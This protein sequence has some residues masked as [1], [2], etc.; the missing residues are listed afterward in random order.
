MVRVF[1][2]TPIL[3][4]AIG[5]ILFLGFGL[6]DA[7]WEGESSPTPTATAVPTATSWPMPTPF[8]IIRKPAES[9]DT[10]TRE[11]RWDYAGHEWTWALPVP[12]ALYDHYSSI[13]RAPTENY[14][15]YVTHPAD[16]SYV[17]ALVDKIEEAAE[18]EGFDEW[19]TVNFAVCFVQSL[20]YTSD[21]AT[22]PYDEYPRYPVETLVDGG[23]DCED[24]SILMA[25]VLDEMGYG[26]IL[27]SLPQHMAVGV[28]GGEGTYGTYW[29]HNGKRYFYLETTGEGWQ[30]GEL[31]VAYEGESADIYDIVPVPI[32]AHEWEAT[33]EANYVN[34]TVTV[35]NR[36]AEG[37]VGTY[38]CAGFHAGGGNLWNPEESVSRDLAPG[39]RMTVTMQLLVPRDKYTRLVVQVVDDGYAVD[40]S[41]SEWFPSSG[42]GMVP[43]SGSFPPL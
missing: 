20:P 42:F 28:L 15:I 13:P 43:V 36:G 24:T 2:I 14:S 35:E 33:T 3:L 32:L 26:V 39:H 18:S 25:A 7:L 19:E 40:E 22:T 21:S 8:E 1:V 37:A 9:P 17:E 4:S 41:Y 27:L 38:V 6:W 23:G 30:I 16:D 34:L 31:P 10:I 29:E 11:Y 12:Q 5:M